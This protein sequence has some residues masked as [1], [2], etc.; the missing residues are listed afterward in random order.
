MSSHEYSIQYL[1]HTQA[2]FDGH[3][4]L[5]ETDMK[6]QFKSF[7]H[8]S[9]SQLSFTVWCEVAEGYCI[10]LSQLLPPCLNKYLVDLFDKYLKG[11]TKE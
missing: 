9:M 4:P 3:F 11:Y 1:S 2:A 10:I 8:K 6:A 7:F 5:L